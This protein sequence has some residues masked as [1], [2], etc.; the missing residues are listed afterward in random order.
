L[1]AAAC[2]GALAAY[3]GVNIFTAKKPVE[4][5]ALAVLDHSGQLQIQW[6]HASRTILGASRGVIEIF[7]GPDRRTFPVTAQ[8]L[9]QGGYTYTRKSGDVQV[10]MAI[11]DSRGNQ[12]QEASRFL[13]SPPGTAPFS[14]P[15]V[16][17]PPAGSPPAGGK[18]NVAAQSVQ[19]PAAP[20]P[21]AP[22]ADEKELR[23]E[24]AREKARIQQLERIVVILQNRL[25]I[26]EPNLPEAK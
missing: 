8:E 11:T 12:T 1:A 13:G 7:D 26:A 16:S 18:E 24:N 6:N 17:R 23:A 9:A 5:F 19:P 15:P 25:S 3:S 14:D 20:S 4:P 2:V 22:S 21:A 10:R